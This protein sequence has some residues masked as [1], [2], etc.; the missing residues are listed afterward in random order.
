MSGGDPC[1]RWAEIADRRA[2]GE[3][4]VGADA[5]FLLRHAATCAACGE[6]ARVYSSLEGLLEPSLVEPPIAGAPELAATPARRRLTG[7]G[8]ALAAGVLATLAAAAAV[9]LH[10]RGKSAAPPMENAALPLAAATATVTLLEGEA[11]VDG[12]HP[13]AGATLAD[14]A[15][16]STGTGRTCVRLDPGV[17]VCLAEASRVR[18]E[19]L[20]GPARVLRLERGRVA[21]E[22]EPQ[23]PG[24]TFSVAAAEGSV[25]AIGTAFSVELA[26]GKRPVARVMHGVVLVREPHQERRLHAHEGARFGEADVT[27]DLPTQEEDAD[28]AL[29]RDGIATNSDRS[30]RLTLDSSPAGAPVRIDGALVGTT[31]LDLLVRPGS[32][33]VAVQGAAGAESLD[34]RA[35]EHVARGWAIASATTAP[36]ASATTKPAL[37][38]SEAESL[39]AAAR[40]ARARGDTAA[41][42]RAYR[43]LLATHAGSAEAH[44]AALSLADLEL[45]RGAAD[46]AL[47]LFERYLTHGGPMALEARYGRIRALE[48]LGRTNEAQA[49]TASFLRDYA[50]SPQADALRA[51]TP[52]P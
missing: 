17:R 38:A 18:I 27:H 25:T 32:H 50:G 15:T 42:A 29:L 2:V 30:A 28:R 22:L 44:A 43:S 8:A 5:V 4:V 14:G 19:N 24:T 41:A 6:E 45:A 34:L 33:V 52:A 3:D 23:P 7:R 46:E 31:P 40:A 37:R 20:E 26:E 10:V 21:A 51:R 39:L 11:T 35:G 12:A 48:R 13:A 9:V 49:A 1:A 47:R 36:P 16:I